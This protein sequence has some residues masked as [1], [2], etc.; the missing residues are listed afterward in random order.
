MLINDAPGL[1]VESRDWPSII[2][3]TLD[4]GRITEIDVVRNPEKLRTLA[5]TR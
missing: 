4:N 1:L 3:F 2:S 5:S